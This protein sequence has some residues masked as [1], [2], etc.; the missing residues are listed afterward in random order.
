[1]LDPGDTKKQLQLKGRVINAAGEAI[2]GATVVAVSDQ[3]F[4]RHPIEAELWEGKGLSSDIQVTQTNVLG[5]FEFSQN[6]LSRKG[7][8]YQRIW[9]RATHHCVSHM[10]DCPTTCHMTWEMLRSTGGTQS[11]VG[12]WMKR[13][14]RSP[15][16][17]F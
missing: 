2:P 15:A 6:L 17:R 11:G 4:Q 14:S 13:A 10:N 1:M 9:L 3:H 12:L 8:F 5:Q 16:C 7:A